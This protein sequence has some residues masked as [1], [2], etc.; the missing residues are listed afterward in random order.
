MPWLAA[1]L[2]PRRKLSIEI[3]TLGS[4]GVTAICSLHRYSTEVAAKRGQPS[5]MTLVSLW[6]SIR[7][8][9]DY[10]VNCGY[11]EKAEMFSDRYRIRRL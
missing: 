7:G 11:S 1:I 8:R 4:G 6:Y 5:G 9:E 10:L 2:S 3:C